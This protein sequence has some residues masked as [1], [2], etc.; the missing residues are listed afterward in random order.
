MRI[1][2]DVNTNLMF[3]PR[4]IGKPMVSS[5]YCV[6]SN[7]TKHLASILT[8]LVQRPEHHVRISR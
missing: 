8:L 6:T 2:T 7:M 5:I 1:Y 4:F 3:S